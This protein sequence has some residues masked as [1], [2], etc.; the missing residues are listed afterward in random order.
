MAPS[1]PPNVH[2]SQHPCLRAKLSQL[3]SKSASAK[4]VKSLVHEIALIVACEALGSAV[5]AVDGPK[6][7]I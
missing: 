4:E 6:V 1:L 5:T 3:R 7:D 2:V